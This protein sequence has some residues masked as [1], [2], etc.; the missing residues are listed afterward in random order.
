[1]DPDAM[2]AVEVGVS[3]NGVEYSSKSGTFGFAWVPE[4]AVVV[5]Q[6]KSAP[7]TASVDVTVTG[8]NLVAKSM[9]SGQ[10]VSAPQCRLSSRAGHGLELVPI[11]VDGTVLN[12]SSIICTIT[13]PN[14][15]FRGTLGTH[16]FFHAFTTTHPRTHPSH[17]THAPQ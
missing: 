11:V 14:V 8:A 7:V 10:F 6:P 15:V 13:C 1:V 12:T 9:P 16:P 17:T 5:V 4:P 2:V 3:N